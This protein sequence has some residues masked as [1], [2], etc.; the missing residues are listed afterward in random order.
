MPNRVFR[1]AATHGPGVGM[2]TYA[3][4]AGSGD[5]L[6]AMLG[7]L[8]SGASDAM[9]TAGSAYRAHTPKFIQNGLDMY[10]SDDPNVDRLFDQAQQAA[11]PLSAAVL[12]GRVPR[13]AAKAV[14]T[15]KNAGKAAD[16]VDAARKA[17]KAAQSISSADTSRKQIAALLKQADLPAGSKNI[18]YGGG[19]YDLGTDFLRGRGVES[20]VFDPFNRDAA[21]NARVLSSGPYDTATMA[22]VLNVIPEREAQLEALRKVNDA[23]KPGGSLWV[24]TYAGN[25]SGAGAA[26]KD[27][28]QHNLPT[29][30]YLPLVQ[31]VFPEA[32]I[33]SGN[34]YAPKAAGLLADEV[35]APAV[36]TPPLRAPAVHTGPLT[37]Q[38]GMPLQDID[39]S[40][41]AIPVQGKKLTVDDVGRY[42]EAQTANKYGV[43]P[44]DASFDSK[45]N[46][47]MEAS[48][49]EF[50][51]QL[52]QPNPNLDF[53][54]V[55]T[56]KSDRMLIQHAFPELEDPTNM[57]VY[58]ALSAVMS[59][60]STPDNDALYGAMLYDR[61][62]NG[63]VLPLLQDSGKNWPAQGAHEQLTKIK[64]MLDTLGEKGMVDFLN[65]PQTVADIRRFRPA[66][67]GKASEL[68][69]GSYVLGNKIGNY[70]GDLRGIVPSDTA[71]T[72]VDKWDMRRS[73]RQRGLLFDDAGAMIEAPRTELDRE[74]NQATHRNLADMFNIGAPRE[75]QSGQWHY[76]QDLYRRLG[77]PVRSLKRSAGTREFL[78]RRGIAPGLLGE[79]PE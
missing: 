63:K 65:N 23:L 55:D 52:Q 29:K 68:V 53:Y 71:R 38:P 72:T 27:G 66:Q 30:D 54:S 43:V 1:N 21:H 31:E 13:M 7:G 15:L 16:A 25:K 12:A 73:S 74:V 69:P 45:L 3:P 2:R 60:N 78:I 8:L 33:R 47:A 5:Q 36:I 19:K 20:S 35:Q 79:T 62:R 40:R 46:R 56:P 9:D 4:P 37:W 49:P 70:Y 51:D 75:A 67:P 34:I 42:L 50:R 14:K 18:D 39:A 17:E 32:K 76:E 10:F 59:N 48:V 58:K 6:P 22:N 64:L 61:Y 57:G 44:H 26:T 24:S 28:F 77:L 41:L 11:G